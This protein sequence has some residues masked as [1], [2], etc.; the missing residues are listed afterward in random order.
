MQRINSP[1]LHTAWNLRLQQQAGT[2]KSWFL[3]KPPQTDPFLHA[4]K[5]TI[6]PTE[7][8]TKGPCKH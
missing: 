2:Q 1:D 8:S 4:P 7:L 3:A 5:S 6:R